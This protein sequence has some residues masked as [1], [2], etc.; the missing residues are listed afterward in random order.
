MVKVEHLSS[1]ERELAYRF[2]SS[3]VSRHALLVVFAKCSVEY[4]GRGASK[5][6]EGDR[7]IVVKPD[8]AVLV[9][10]P[11]GYSPV[12]WQPDSRVID[13]KLEGNHVVVTSVRARPREVLT[14]R[15]SEVYYALAVYGMEDR[16]EFI[17][18]L[19]EHEIRDFLASHPD[20][21]EPGLR[22][23]RVEKP[24]EP[25]F[26]D[27]YAV[28]SQGNYVVIEIKR[29]TAGKDAVVQ[30]KRYVDALRKANPNARIR[31]ILVA[32]GISKQALEL[33]S[34][35]KLEY[36]QISLEKLYREV[37]REQQKTMQQL[38][39]LLDYMRSTSS[40]HGGQ[41]QQAH[42]S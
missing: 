2:I 31:G 21:I 1:S 30:L 35:Y 14:I 40:R 13:V 16:A 36:K 6:G 42:E 23:V 19:D 8:G 41:L 7:M 5:L 25:G 38:K 37:K 11:T 29:V 39:S 3:A 24:V 15:I 22:I 4:E 17:E 18:Y 32:P 26:V 12:N 20:Y 34:A 33:L 27:L 28:D 10:R 9:H